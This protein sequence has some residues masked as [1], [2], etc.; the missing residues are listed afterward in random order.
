MTNKLMK[1][2]NQIE[3][4]W[5]S[6]VI[7]LFSTVPIFAAGN[8]D[9]GNSDITALLQ[10]A[11]GAVKTIISGIFDPLCIVALGICIVILVLG[12]NSKSA[13]S[14]MSWAKRIIICFIVFN[15]LGTLLA[16]VTDVAFTGASGF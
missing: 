12:R 4:F 1:Y 8:S 10:Q 6:L 13:D 2:K 11:I 7:T 3:A 5:A 16:W 15:I 9:A 14:S